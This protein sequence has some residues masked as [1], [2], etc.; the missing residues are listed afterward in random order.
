V[1]FEL[2]SPVAFDEVI[3][4]KDVKLKDIQ[5]HVI[6]CALSQNPFYYFSNLSHYFPNIKSLSDLLMMKIIWAI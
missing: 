6:Y 4:S 1:F 5:K 3:K 2:E